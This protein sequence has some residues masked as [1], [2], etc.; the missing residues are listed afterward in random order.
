[1][2]WA[3]K[4]DVKEK[5]ARNKSQFYKKHGNAAGRD[6]SDDP[7]QKRRRGD[8]E[9]EETMKARLDNDLDAF[10]AEDDEA[11]EPAEPPSKM[12]SANMD[13]TGQSLLDRTSI[14]PARPPRH[15]NSRRDRNS[16]GQNRTGKGRREARPPPRQS[17]S[18][19]ELDDELDAFLNEKD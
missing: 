3:R 16:E 17:K 2:R 15:Q 13:S 6:A 10:L 5:G 11:V 18:Q 19:Q 4:D 8:G 7:V 9:S 14:V 1:M 12:R